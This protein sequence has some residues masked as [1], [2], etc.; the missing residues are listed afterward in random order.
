MEAHGR[1]P[2]LLAQGGSLRAPLWATPL[3]HVIF[4]SGI[5]HELTLL[6]E[7]R[8]AQVLS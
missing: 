8:N 5:P 6:C 3:R 7:D 4:S 1:A 2:P